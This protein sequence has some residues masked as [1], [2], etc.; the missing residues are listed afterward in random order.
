[1]VDDDGRPRK[2]DG[3][4]RALATIALILSLIALFWAMK[5]DNRAGD[6]LDTAR[7]NT[8]IIENVQ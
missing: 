8:P 6:A 4:A 7:A 3:L 1:M 2:S 5:A